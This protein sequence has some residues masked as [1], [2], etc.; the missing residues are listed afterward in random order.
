[1]D[2]PLPPARRFD[3]PYVVERLRA[4]SVS[5]EDARAS[6]AVAILLRAGADGE[7]EVLFIERAVREGDPWSGHMAF[8]GG[9]RDDTD[10]DA[11]ATAVRETWEEVGI[12]VARDARL[13]TRLDDIP[14][15]IQSAEINMRVA[16]FVFEMQRDVSHTLSSEVADVLW[17]PIAPLVRAEVSSVFPFTWQ[18]VLHELPCYK[19]G[20]RV[21]W[22][23]TYWMLE[24][25]FR[26]L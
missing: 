25:L 5:L 26:P 7:T 17:T 15:V 13:I 1:M 23:L 6:A 2:H 11:L 16:P 12:D 8:P 10:A 20:E 22:G 9:R 14:V 18:G 21:I 19:L 24:A 3:L 4:R